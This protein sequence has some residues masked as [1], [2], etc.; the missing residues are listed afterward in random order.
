MS[1]R[2]GIVGGHS[3]I[4]LLKHTYLMATFRQFR[5]PPP[6]LSTHE[7]PPS[8]LV[9]MYPTAPAASSMPLAELDT[10]YQRLIWELSCWT[11]PWP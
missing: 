6:R 1:D 5:S 4:V 2:K 3:T 7:T 8:L 10:A 11:H 9:N